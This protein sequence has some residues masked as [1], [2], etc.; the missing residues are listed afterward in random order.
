MTVV[1]GIIREVGPSRTVQVSA[2]RWYGTTEIVI[3]DT[4]TKKTYS[5]RI[6]ANTL[7]KCRFLPRVGMPVV[8]HGYVEEA[9]SG[10][11]DY[12]VSRVTSIKH[13]DAGIKKIYR[14][15]NE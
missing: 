7:D 12:V 4:E 5:V 6:S 10:L 3:Q 8:I 13:E 11:S 14:F 1:R 15:D 2:R 9:E